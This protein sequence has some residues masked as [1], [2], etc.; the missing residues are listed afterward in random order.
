M[1]HENKTA[2]EL[3]KQAQI[4][5]K[6]LEQGAAK[7]QAVKDRGGDTLLG[8]VVQELSS[9]NR[10]MR[11]IGEKYTT[12]KNA[13]MAI[14]DKFLQPIGHAIGA[15]VGPAYR[16]CMWLHA[17]TDQ[18]AYDKKWQKR[19]AKVGRVILLAVAISMGIQAIPASL[20]G[21]L[22]RTYTTEVAHDAGRMALFY[23][24]KETVFLDFKQE[25]DP[26]NDE[27]SVSGCTK[28]TAVCETKDA[29]YFLVKP[30]IVHSFWSLFNKGIKEPFFIPDHVVAPI[31]HSGSKC[32]VTSYGAR[33][34]ISTIL[35]AYPYLLNAKC[36]SVNFREMFEG[37]A[38]KAEMPAPTVQQQ[39]SVQAPAGPQS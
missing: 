31:S 34:R 22:V 15:V 12:A 6:G 11:G 29:V 38:S 30:S 17:K 26:Q 18:Q 7:A 4:L 35:Q 3:L 25:I 16:G 39:A 27:W 23:N 33:W 28:A 14:Y 10:T 21:D 24:A 9:F 19:A 8:Q 32:E 13:C 20:G 1:T 5:Q 36:T 2:D 37:A